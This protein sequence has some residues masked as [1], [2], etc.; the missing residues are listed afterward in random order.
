[1]V[2][3]VYACN[4]NR[5]SRLVSNSVQLSG[6]GRGPGIPHHGLRPQNPLGL[7]PPDPAIL[8]R[9]LLDPPLGWAFDLE[10]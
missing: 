2:H 3:C 7:R 5:L 1:M 10:N 8:R 9:Q 6:G 4:N